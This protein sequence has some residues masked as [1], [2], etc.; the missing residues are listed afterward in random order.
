MPEQE[1]R[2]AFRL[3]AEQELRKR[4]LPFWMERAVDQRNGGFYGEVTQDGMPVDTAPKG[5][6]LGSRILWT[7]AHATLCF[8]DQ[9]Y[10]EYARRAYQYLCEH[11][12]D[13]QHAGIYWSVDA[14]G[15]PLDTAKHIYAQSFAIYGLAEYFRATG[16]TEA[17]QK[18]RQIFELIKQ[19]AHTPLTGGYLESYDREWRLVRDARLSSEEINAA[20]TMNTHLHLLEAFTNLLR[21]WDERR[22][23][24]RLSEL[25][26]TFLEHIIDPQTHHFSLFFEADWTPK[27]NL[28]SFGHDIEGSWLLCEV[29]D[30]L[31]EAQ[32]QRRA[33]AV[34]LQMAQ[35]VYNE[36][37]DED[38]ALLSEA[39][40]GEGITNDAKE[41][42]PQ[43][44]N[45]VGMLN[46]SQLSGEEAYFEASY[47]C[48]QFIQDYMVDKQ[49]EN[50]IWELTCQRVPISRPL[51]QLLEMPLSQQPGVFRG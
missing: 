10:L 25:I 14:L 26:E 1:K 3:E 7:F 9:A 12:W 18:A 21:V 39:T 16:D 11:L 31:G 47:R 43:A 15:Q 42:W 35:A 37:M 22:L 28:I 36:G 38:G 49:Q 51:V 32:V 27:S 8:H 45:V 5:G 40:E 13:A 19:H 2:Q 23:R 46:A 6:I 41:W 34:A 33:R 29:A 20:K 24:E 48:W 4:I 30:V 44:E 17:L 50:G